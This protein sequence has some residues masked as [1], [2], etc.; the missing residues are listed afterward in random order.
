V[1]SGCHEQ[2]R[3]QRTGWWVLPSG[4]SLTT[5]CLS[6]RCD[7]AHQTYAQHTGFPEPCSAVST[8]ASRQQ[9]V[10]LWCN[11]LQPLTDTDHDLVAILII[12]SRMASPA[13]RRLLQFVLIDE[14]LPR[15]V[16]TGKATLAFYAESGLLPTQIKLKC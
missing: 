8:P 10:E 6:R 16:G 5:E 4:F 2:A 11:C 15:R 13:W 1:Y 3:A 7:M 12:L 9:H 14:R